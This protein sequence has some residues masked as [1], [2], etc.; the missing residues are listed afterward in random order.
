[1]ALK[2]PNITNPVQRTG[3]KCIEI[4]ILAEKLLRSKTVFMPKLMYRLSNETHG[5]KRKKHNSQEVVEPPVFE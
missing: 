1:M 5:E 4:K 3:Y 2:V